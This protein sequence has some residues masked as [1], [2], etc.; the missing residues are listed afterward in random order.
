[1]NLLVKSWRSWRSYDL[2]GLNSYRKNEQKSSF[3][4]E[5]L[6]VYVERS[7]R[8]R[9]IVVTCPSRPSFGGLK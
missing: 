9:T 7:R 1:M 5:S 2:C 3:P 8:S 6:N 4:I